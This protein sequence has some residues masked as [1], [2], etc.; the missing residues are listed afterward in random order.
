MKF[1]DPG[2]NQPIR[3][4]WFMSANSWPFELIF[5]RFVDQT[6]NKGGGTWRMGSQWKQVVNN[7]GDR[8]RPPKDRVVAAP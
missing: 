6:P 8:F 7:Y 2:T 4:I 5:G 1:Q 3:M